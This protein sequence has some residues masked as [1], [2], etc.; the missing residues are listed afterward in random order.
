MNRAMGVD[1]LP[2]ANGL[3]V[4]VENHIW[5]HRLGHGNDGTHGDQDGEDH[6]V[7]CVHG[8]FLLIMR[9]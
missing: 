6:N 5:I 9:V 8:S 1:S 7:Q 4:T 2:P 3:D